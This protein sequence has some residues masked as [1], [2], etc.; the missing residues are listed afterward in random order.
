VYK[1]GNE[2]AINITDKTSVGIISNIKKKFKCVKH[3]KP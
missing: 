2:T 3:F 1:E